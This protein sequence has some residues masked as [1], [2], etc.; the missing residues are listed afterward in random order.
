MVDRGMGI[1][2]FNSKTALQEIL[3]EFELSDSEAE[4]SSHS[5][6]ELDVMSRTA[7]VISQLRQF[8]VQVGLGSS[9]FTYNPFPTFFFG[10]RST[11]CH[12]YS[13]IHAKCRLMIC[14]TSLAIIFG[15]IKS[16]LSHCFFYLA[17]LKAMLS[18]I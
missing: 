8:V 17:S 14:L 7:V 12:L 5:G 9:L 10:F 15:D 16:V 1:R 2:L 13:L 11:S 18:S 3:Q 6:D 4:G